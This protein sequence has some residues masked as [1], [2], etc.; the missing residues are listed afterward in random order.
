MKDWH[1]SAKKEKLRRHENH[2]RIDQGYKEM[3]SIQKV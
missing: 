2:S 3:A 1:I